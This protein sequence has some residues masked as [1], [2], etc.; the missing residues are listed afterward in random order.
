MNE[1][2]TQRLERINEKME[3]MQAQRQDILNREKKRQRAERTRRLI[4]IGALAEKYFDMKDIQPKDFEQFLEI[5]MKMNGI[6]NC[7]DYAKNPQEFEKNNV[8][9]NG[10]VNNEKGVNTAS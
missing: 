1:R 7:V 9:Q 6:R 2:D 8:I 3:Q 4:Q 10:V 5:F